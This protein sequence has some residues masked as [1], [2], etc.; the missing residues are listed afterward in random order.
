M[1]ISPPKYLK[2]TEQFFIWFLSYLNSKIPIFLM[3]SAVLKKHCYATIVNRVCN[4]Y[5]S[6]A[7]EEVKSA[8]GYVVNGEVQVD[9]NFILSLA[10]YLYTSLRVWEVHA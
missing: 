5:L 7:Q 8:R 9:F 6:A 4:E 1:M 10:T 3:T 2:W